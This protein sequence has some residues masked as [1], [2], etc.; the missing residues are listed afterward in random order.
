MAEIQPL[1][2]RN[3]ADWADNDPPPRRWVVPGLLPAG[4]VSLLTGDG[5]TGKTL[6]AIQL[7]LSATTGG[8]WLGREVAQGPVLALLGEDDWPETGRRLRAIAAADEIDLTAAGQFHVITKGDLTDT[9]LGVGRDGTVGPTPAFGRLMDAIAR[10][11]PVLVIVDPLAEVAAVDEN[12]RSEA[13]GFIRLMGR[14]ADA[15]GAAIL[16]LGHPSLTGLA[17]G[18]GA[19]GSTGWGAAVRSRLFLSADERN[20]TLRRLRLGKSNYAKSGETI[21]MIYS[22]GC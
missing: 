9:A 22:A 18:T 7:G 10:I 19:S 1:R 2:L 4:C 15:S 11:K 14:L 16:L 3:V 17:N 20:P 13:A 21:E 12:R 8:T 6:L 5:G